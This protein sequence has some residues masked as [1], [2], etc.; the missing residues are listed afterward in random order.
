METKGLA[1]DPYNIIITGVGGQGNVMASRILGNM[2]SLAGF[3]VTIGETFG[4]SQ[5]GGSVMS[6]LS[7]SRES[8]S[9]PL[10][11]KGKA[12]L[13]VSLEPTEGIR[14]LK[15]YGNPEVLMLT[16]TR[17]IHPVGVIAGDLAYPPLEQIK[18]WAGELTARSWFIDAT[19]RAM[20]MG[21]P[22]LGNVIMIGA[23]CGI[24]VV[25]VGKSQFEAVISRDL[26]PDK[27]RV[28]LAAFDLGGSLVDP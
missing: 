6:H 2:L 16:N 1:H 27:I 21:N 20:E 7:V 14:V 15:D 10:I 4:G 11:P 8:V 25:P 19:D 3:V 22:I 18:Q 9:S 5:R 12:H 26:K 24:D 28:N 13:V 17:P 23:V